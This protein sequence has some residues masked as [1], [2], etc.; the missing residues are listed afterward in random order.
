MTVKSSISLTDEQH[1]LAKALVD[2]GRYSSVSAVIQQSIEQLRQRLGV[3]DLEHR[4][5]NEILSRH[6]SGEFVGAEEMDKR[7]N[8]RLAGKRRTHGDRRRKH[9]S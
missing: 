7:L 8:R 2:S 1:A 9:R 3:E 4:A 6:R 5:L